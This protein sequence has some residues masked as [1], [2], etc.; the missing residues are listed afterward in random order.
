MRRIGTGVEPGNHTSDSDRGREDIL[1]EYDFPA[2]LRVTFRD[3]LD[4][5]LRETLVACILQ[6]PE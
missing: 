1:R 2:Y 5:S 3:K 4:E 6:P